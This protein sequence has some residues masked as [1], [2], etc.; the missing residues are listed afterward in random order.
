MANI[1]FEYAFMTDIENELTFNTT[2]EDKTFV[3]ALR[4][5]CNVF[6][7]NLN[8]YTKYGNGPLYNMANIE[9]NTFPEHILHIYN[10][11]SG[12]HF[13]PICKIT[14]DDNKTKT[15]LFT[16]QPTR[17]ILI[18]NIPISNIPISNISSKMFGGEDNEITNNK[19]IDS[20][21][22]MSLP[23]QM[24]KL[25][26][27]I[28]S[29][30]NHTKVLIDEVKNCKILMELYK[31]STANIDDNKLDNKN[32]TTYSEKYELIEKSIDNLIE[33]LKINYKN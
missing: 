8:F 7:F 25:M 15:L 9:S 29:I 24:L 32:I 13:E 2:N 30:N 3:G 17:N 5:L 18:S 21:D 4:L 6:G 16:T 22:K 11:S 12:L 31:N 26:F 10:D 14:Y 28:P 23:H 20:N 33:Q 27:L 1:N 19:Q